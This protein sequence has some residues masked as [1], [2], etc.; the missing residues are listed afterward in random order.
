MIVPA[1]GVGVSS[2]SLLLPVKPTGKGSVRAR[3]IPKKGSV[4]CRS[5]KRR[6]TFVTTYPDPKSDKWEEA[7]AALFAGAW[8]DDPLDEPC[9]LLVVSVFP[10]PKSKTRKTKPNPR[11]LHT[12]KPDASNVL[13]AVED[14]LVKGGV[15]KDDSRLFDSRSVKFVAGDGDEVGVSVRLRWGRSAVLFR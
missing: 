11:Y 9:S 1:T 14:A 4:P 12:V 15:L 7:A 2:W 6:E 10:R 8:K 5:C 13:K 3:A